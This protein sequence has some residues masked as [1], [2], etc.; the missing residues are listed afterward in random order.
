MGNIFHYRNKQDVHFVSSSIPSIH[1]I[2][3]DV[4]PDSSL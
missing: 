3:Q 2:L 4:L 1:E